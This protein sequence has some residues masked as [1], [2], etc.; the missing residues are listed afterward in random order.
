MIT[1]AE[2]FEEVGHRMI[3]DFFDFEFLEN[4]EYAFQPLT[5]D[6]IWAL[7]FRSPHRRGTFIATHL[8]SD[9]NVREFYARQEWQNNGDALLKVVVSNGLYER[10]HQVWNEHERNNRE[11]EVGF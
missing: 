1:P 6:H 2:V 10:L 3:D 5:G 9:A 7:M 4:V 11:E 8:M